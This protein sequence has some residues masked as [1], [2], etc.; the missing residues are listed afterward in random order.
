MKLLN[1]KR[2]LVV[3]SMLLIVLLAGCS[4]FT[5]LRKPLYNGQ[6][7][8]SKT[9]AINI[10]EQSA[11]I[12]G[13]EKEYYFRYPF[14]EDIYASS[15]DFSDEEPFLLEEGVYTIGEDLPAGRVSLVGNESVFTSDNYDVHVGNLIIR[16]QTDAIYFENLF[17]SLY[18]QLVAQVDFLPGHTIEIIGVEAEITVFYSE[19]V[20]E[21][22]Y[23]LMDAPELL[24]N[25]ERLHVPQPI[26]RDEETQSITLTAGIYEVGQH[27]E[28]GIYEIRSVFAPHN[29]EMYHFIE[30]EETKVYELILN[31]PPL[32]EE[33]AGD[34][35]EAPT[36]ET[37]RIF[38]KV[39]LNNGDKIYPSLTYSLTLTKVDE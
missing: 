21:D 29:T 33:T 28:P 7:I 36:V 4:G 8:E 16:D 3:M 18:G 14:S 38:P 20:P 5:G 30:G 39:N 1:K 12:T 10:Y 32:N 27:F 22:P 15:L 23:L 9:E 37:E 31:A 13:E 24:V 35:S 25:L 2:P 19:M 6:V 26:V 34:L 17:H 11:E